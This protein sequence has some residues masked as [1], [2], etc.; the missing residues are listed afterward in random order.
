M[1]VHNTTLV[2]FR[3]LPFIKIWTTPENVWENGSPPPPPS[4]K[5]PIHLSLNMYGYFFHMNMKKNYGSCCYH[6]HINFFTSSQWSVNVYLVS[7]GI[8]SL[9][10]KE[11]MSIWVRELV[12]TTSKYPH[13]GQHISCLICVLL[14]PET[15]SIRSNT[16]CQSKQNQNRNCIP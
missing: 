13:F 2:S 6:L 10:I 1:S 7:E 3:L 15:P 4:K 8:S 16:S 14:C 9:E 12:G 5:L 11:E